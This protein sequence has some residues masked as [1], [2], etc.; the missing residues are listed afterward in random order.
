MSDQKTRSWVGEGRQVPGYPLINL[1]ICLSDVPA[2]AVKSHK[3]GKKYLNLTVGERKNGEDQYGNT[4]SI[5]VNDYKPE[6]KSET[7]VEESA[8]PF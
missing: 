5:W 3:N 7:V 8:L 2:D 1:N 6:P 4:H